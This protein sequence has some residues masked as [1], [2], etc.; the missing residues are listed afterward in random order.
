MQHKFK[1]VNLIS[2]EVWEQ[3]NELAYLK[4]AYV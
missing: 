3:Q 4:Y 2:K 1:D